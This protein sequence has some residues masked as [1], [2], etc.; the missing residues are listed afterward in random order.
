MRGLLP[1]RGTVAVL[2]R[3]G[4]PFYEGLNIFGEHIRLRTRQNENGTFTRQ[5]ERMPTVN[6]DRFAANP[7]TNFEHNINIEEFV[8]NLGPLTTGER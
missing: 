4:M 7:V 6:P 2:D 3:H 5:W 8:R 1:R